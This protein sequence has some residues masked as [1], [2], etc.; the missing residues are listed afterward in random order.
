MEKDRYGWGIV[1]DV[2]EKGE[3]G[4]VEIKWNK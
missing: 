1:V 4:S 2:I 3:I